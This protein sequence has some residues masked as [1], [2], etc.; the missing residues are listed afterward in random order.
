MSIEVKWDVRDEESGER[1][2]YLAE[3]FA[4]QWHFKMRVTRR[5]IWDRVEP[6]REMWEEVLDALLR[7]LPRRTAGVEESDV[8]FVKKALSELP[9]D[10]E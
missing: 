2:Y 8:A 4:R 3:K 7:R 5:G 9:P 6:T 10:E 1:R